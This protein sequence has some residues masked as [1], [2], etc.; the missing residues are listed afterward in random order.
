MSKNF[1]YGCTQKM[2]IYNKHPN[3]QEAEGGF[4]TKLKELK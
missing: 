2:E 3:Q 4:Q 1:C